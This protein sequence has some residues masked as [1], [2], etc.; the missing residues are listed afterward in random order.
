MTSWL[1]ISLPILIMS[2][3][4]ILGDGYGVKVFLS[5]ALITFVIMIDGTILSTRKEKHN[6]VS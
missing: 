4:I 6:D 2:A 3:I 1:L 5:L